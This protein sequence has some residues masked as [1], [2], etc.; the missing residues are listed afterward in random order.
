MRTVLQFNTVA[1]DSVNLPREI[2]AG[3]TFTFF[4][5]NSN[6]DGEDVLSESEEILVS[7]L[8]SFDLTRRLIFKELNISENVFYGLK[9]IGPIIKD[10]RKKPGD[11]DVLICENQKPHQAI[12]LECKRV[13]VKAIDMEN[14][15]VNKIEKIRK[16]VEQANALRELGF[17]KTFLTILVLAD[18]RER[19][20]YNFL[21]RDPTTE[22]YKQIY[23]FPRDKLH[24]DVGVIFVE[25]DQ[26]IGKP[27]NDAAV[28]GICIDKEAKQLEQPIHLT[29]RINE[30]IR[31]KSLAK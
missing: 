12:A 14:D 20:E 22:T 16:G 8:F 3:T 9:I 2:A 30:L 7:W 11:I 17:H 21:A 5:D 19:K 6:L 25:I 13:K 18:G 26:P 27:I 28:V 1:F 10:V 24:D 29:N 4:V 31:I 15:K 23:D